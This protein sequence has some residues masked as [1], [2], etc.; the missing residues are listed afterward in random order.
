MVAR[1]DECFQR[2]RRTGVK[3]TGSPN[4]YELGGAGVAAGA[5]LPLTRTNPEMTESSSEL[6]WSS[7]PRVTT[8]RCLGRAGIVAI[9]LYELHVA[10]GT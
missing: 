9:G 6:S 4:V 2:F 5:A 10:A 8:V 1:R 7:R 3:E